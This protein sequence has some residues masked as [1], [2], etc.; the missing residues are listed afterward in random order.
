[1]LAEFI[2]KEISFKW[3]T[4]VFEEIF[5]IYISSPPYLVEPEE[6]YLSEWYVGE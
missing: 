6:N 1:M 3:N 4:F 5:Q 2:N